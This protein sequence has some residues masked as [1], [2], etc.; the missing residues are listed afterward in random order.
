MGILLSESNQS[1]SAPIE[2]QTSRYSL[3]LLNRV[4]S[5][6]TRLVFPWVNRFEK[7]LTFKVWKEGNKVYE[8]SY[9]INK[10]QIMGWISLF[11][12]PFDESK[13]IKEMYYE[14]TV[15]FIKGFEHIIDNE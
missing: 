3:F 4:V 9:I 1:V 14:Y 2:K 10:L 6:S 15:R 13:E 8:K 7:E 11:I 12:F 5:T